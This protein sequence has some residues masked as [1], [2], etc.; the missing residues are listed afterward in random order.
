MMTVFWRLELRFTLFFPELFELECENLKCF[1]FRKWIWCVY[2]NRI[3]PSG[4][5]NNSQKSVMLILLRL[6]KWLFTLGGIDCINSHMS[7]QVGL[8]SQ[9]SYEKSFASSTCAA[10]SAS[11]TP[12][13][14]FRR[15]GK[16]RKIQSISSAQ[17]P[18]HL[19]LPNPTHCSHGLSFLSAM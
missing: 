7:A 3:P 19:D 10:P 16:K 11:L 5:H 18:P 12:Q 15:K 9:R 13:P 8:H 4:I 14:P 6:N 1:D 17:L 2:S